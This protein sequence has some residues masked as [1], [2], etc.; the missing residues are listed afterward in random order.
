MEFAYQLDELRM[1]EMPCEIRLQELL[2]FLDA[3]GRFLIRIGRNL[4]ACS[5]LGTI[6]HRQFAGLTSERQHNAG[7]IS[8][9]RRADAFMHE[10]FWHLLAILIHIS[11]RSVFLLFHL[12][13]LPCPPCANNEIQRS[14]SARASPSS[15][16]WS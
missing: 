1:R 15:S 12:L 6:R 10:S 9:D 11:A 16:S 7:G 2:E 8:T 3:L 5:N 14:A 4:S 13:K